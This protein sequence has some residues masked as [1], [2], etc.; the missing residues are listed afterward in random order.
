VLS[1]VVTPQQ[2]HRVSNQAYN[3]YSPLATIENLLGVGRLGQA[4]GAKAMSDLVQTEPRT[5][6]LISR[7]C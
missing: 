1:L 5:F 4:A 3:H 6:S 2:G 7:P